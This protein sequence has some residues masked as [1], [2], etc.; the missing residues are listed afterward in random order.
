MKE[1]SDKKVDLD[2][3]SQIV[4]MSKLEHIG[5]KERIKKFFSAILGVI[6]LIIFWETIYSIMDSHPILYTRYCYEKFT[7]SSSKDFLFAN[8]DVEDLYYTV[9]EK[10]DMIYYSSEE[11]FSDNPEEIVNSFN[12]SDFNDKGYIYIEGYL[13]NSF[14]KVKVYVNNNIQSNN[15]YDNYDSVFD[16]FYIFS[17]IN[18]FIYKEELLLN[19]QNKITFV[20]GD[21]TYD[22][23]FYVVSE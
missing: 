3:I 12:V 1:K 22:Y 17:R 11:Y 16:E 2:T 13:Y 23:Y 14:E 6:I 20:I 18:V 4:D 7:N 5:I 8:S 19:Q 9:D 15:R 10:I 21:K